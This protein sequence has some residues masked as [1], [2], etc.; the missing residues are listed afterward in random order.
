MEKPYLSN[1]LFEKVKTPVF[2]DYINA[3]DARRM[4]SVM[5]CALASSLKVLQDAGVDKPDAIITGTGVG[6]LDYTQRFLADLH[7]NNEQMLKPTYFMQ[8]THNTIG[9]TLG[10]YTKNNGYNTTY[11]HNG[12]TFEEAVLDAW[13]QLRLNKIQNALVGGH[14]E[15]TQ[16]YFE[17]LQMTGYVGQEGMVPCCGMSGAI[18]LSKECETALCELAGIEIMDKPSHEAIKTATISMLERNGLS[19]NDLSAIMTGV[20]GN[21]TNDKHYNNI[22]EILFKETPTIRYKHLFGENFTSSAMSVYSAA[23]CLAK[24][25]IPRHMA[26]GNTEPKHDEPRNILLLNYA[27]GRECSLILL[28]RC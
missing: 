20:N 7:A 9:S 13:L 17:A 27:G 25:F 12:I 19:V 21:S 14:D 10:I 15:M 16:S 6:S 1:E 26:Y 18:F 4:C 28:K 5:K 24:G 3:S 11:S 2:R 22:T 8:S 23:H